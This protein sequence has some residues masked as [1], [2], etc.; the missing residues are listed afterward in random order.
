MVGSAAVGWNGNSSRRYTSLTDPLTTLTDVPEPTASPSSADAASALPA[1]RPWPDGAATGVGSMPGTDIRAAL[2][3]VLD[4][5]PDLPHLPELPARGPGAEMTGRALA[6]LPDVP[7]EWGPTGWTV[8]DRAGGDVRRAQGFLHED[9]DT[10]E[11][12]LDGWTGPLKTQLCGPWTLA[13]TL[14]L[15]SGRRALSDPG[16]VRD[17][18]QALAEAAGIHVAELSRR[19]P[20]AVVILQL[21]E[22]ALPVVLDGSVPTP[23]GLAR[24][25]AVEPGVARQAL[26]AVAAA[27]PAGSGIAVHCC[28]SQPPLEVMLAAGVGVL[29]IDLAAATAAGASRLDDAVAEAV[30]GGT[31]LLAG[32]I[33]TTITATTTS[34]DPTAEAVLAPLR[35]LWRRTGLPVELLLQV[36]VTPARGL[37]GATP[38]RDRAALQLARNAGRRLADDPEGPRG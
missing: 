20:G 22:P 34:D 19:I 10:L 32:L 27:L 37:A 36:A 29:S 30:E 18:A 12:M 24:L 1:P 13:A 28:A 4:E 17:L 23:S 26:A 35:G 2:G 14:E 6:L 9:L 15:R 8:T 5:L 33:P 25:A 21:D 11:E 7:A 38:G 16:A 31:R 3:I